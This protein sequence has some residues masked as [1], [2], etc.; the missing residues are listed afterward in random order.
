[1]TYQISKAF[2]LPPQTVL[3]ELTAHYS[4]VQRGPPDSSTRIW[5]EISNTLV[6]VSFHTEKSTGP[7]AYSQCCIVHYLYSTSAWIFCG[8]HIRRH[9]ILRESLLGLGSVDQRS[10][11]NKVHKK[12]IEEKRV[13]A[14]I[15]SASHTPLTHSGFLDSAWLPAHCFLGQ[16]LDLSL[17]TY[18]PMRFETVPY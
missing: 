3:Q 7:S 18:Y 14:T 5:L 17:P 9:P 16:S 1:M 8:Y 6:V 10:N 11:I 2:G 13:A 4:F 12:S 15:G